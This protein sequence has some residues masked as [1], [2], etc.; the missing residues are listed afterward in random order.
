MSGPLAGLRIGLL[1]SSASRLGGGVSEVVIVQAGLIRQ[2]G[3]EPAVFALADE[4]T[5]E[6]LHRYGETPVAALPV[7]GPPQI[8]F[9]PALVSRLIDADL[10]CLH[11]H[12][13]WMYP[14]RAATVWS[15]RTGRPYVISPHG[16]L[17]P[18]ITG[19]GRWKK[20][21]ARAGYERASWR[22]ASVLHALTA[23][24]AGD[25]RDE[26][27]RTD[28]L[29]IPNAGPPAGLLPAR[30]RAPNFLYLGRIHPKKNIGALVDAWRSLDAAGRLGGARLTIAGWGME[31]HVAELRRSLDGA[32]ASVE[33]IGPAYGVLKQRLLEEARFLVLPSFS[34]GLPMVVLE[35]WA[36]GTPAIM[37][38]ECNL[39][40]GIAAGAA[41]ECGYDAA[42]IA[43][44]LEQAIAMDDA[45]W[46]EM[47]RAAHG[48]ASGEFSARAI[49]A[50]W[51]EAYTALVRGKGA[52][53]R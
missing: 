6:D 52:R 25:I 33:F 13:I 43:A 26:S 34:E 36:Q 50:R 30:P 47:A 27:G 2:L 9:A 1:T 22:A 31:G 15:G 48:L 11:L 40:E 20:A 46:L 16:M 41:L 42:A 19:R 44:A 21:M 37:T 24:E 23:R 51:A 39:P 10:D 35:A 14:S 4:H 29:V 45:R 12:G 3:G 5:G 53:T 7:T 49:A 8:G 38:G 17:D 28:S 32:P 18:W